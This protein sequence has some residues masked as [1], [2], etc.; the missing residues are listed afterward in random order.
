MTG[1][2]KNGT[3]FGPTHPSPKP[4][5][6]V[7]IWLKLLCLTLLGYALLGKG[8]AYFGVPPIFIGEMILLC[9]IGSFVL[10]GR[11]RG[12]FDMPAVWFLVVLI[13][14][15][16]LRT[17]PDLPRYGADSLR[18]A[19]IW[20]YGI[21]AVIVC[22][23]LLGRPR[24]MAILLRWYRQFALWFPVC[25]PVLWIMSQFLA[26]SLP[27]WPWAKV[28]V[29][30]LKGGDT[31]VHLAGILA[32][33]VA[34]LGGCIATWRLGLLAACVVLVGTFDRSGLLTFLAVFTLCL[35]LKPRDHSLWRLMGLGF[36]GLVLIAATGLRVQMPEREREIS[37][38]QFVANLT[39]L[40]G[41]TRTGDLDETKQWRLD[42][43]SDITRYT[44]HGKYFWTGKGFGINL[45]DE[46]DY[47]V[48]EDSS[49][50]CPHNGHM[51]M[52]A[53]GGVPGL[54]L[55]LLVHLSW[56][57]TLARAYFHSRHAGEEHW[58]G[59]FLFLLA[60]GMA[61]LSNATFDVFLEGPMGGIWYWTV[62]GV[63]L[64]A[65]W[66]YWRQPKALP[67]SWIGN[68]TTEQ[69]APS[70]G[71]LRRGLMVA[72]GKSV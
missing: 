12:L 18:D 20:G 8:G 15:G 24:R 47:Q 53:R 49:L 16:M 30:F 4:Q 3:G 66:T 55:W 72:M 65:S 41:N 48:Q 31:L 38:T 56:A 69:A 59:L 71:V 14:W 61:F 2:E 11:W 62:F 27:R 64:A 37:I 68:L 1:C 9:G 39:S 7:G 54:V 34:G 36:C 17:W 22:G 70:I 51:T 21:F 43:W 63:G 57:C 40:G 52:L 10:F 58:A 42:W 19:V 35:A 33:W 67:W 6:R 44:L 26:E 46:D 28:P 5:A 25:I 60:Y 23:A 50:R 29:L 45:A 13:T 32:F